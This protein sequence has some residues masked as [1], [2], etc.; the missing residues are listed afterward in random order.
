MV[1]V[2]TLKHYVITG[3]MNSEFDETGL[4]YRD[5]VRAHSPE[6]QRHIGLGLLREHGVL[7]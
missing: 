6:A 3:K 4:G 2:P 5:I 1:L 7:Q